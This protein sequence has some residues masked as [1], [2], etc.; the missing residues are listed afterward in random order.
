M[1]KFI[2]T[3]T[4]AVWEPV[5]DWG[6]CG[7]TIGDYGLWYAL[8]CDRTGDAEKP[9]GFATY[10]EGDVTKETF[11][12]AKLRDAALDMW[13]WQWWTLNEKAPKGLPPW[14]DDPAARKAENMPGWARGPYREYR[15]SEW[16]HLGEAV[17]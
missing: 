12:N 13:A 5:L 8:Q 17:G 2:E 14:P 9:F 15:G 3:A 10:T 7:W 6:C 1:I 4:A 16:P 11:A